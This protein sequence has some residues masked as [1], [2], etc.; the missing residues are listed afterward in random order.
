M[1]VARMRQFPRREIRGFDRIKTN[2]GLAS[3][4]P[5]EPHEK[6]RLWNT[7]LLVKAMVLP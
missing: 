5:R 7:Y 4:G 2:E 6:G 1:E 3:A